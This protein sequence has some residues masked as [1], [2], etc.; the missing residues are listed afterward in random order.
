MTKPSTSSHFTAA[1]LI[2][3]L[4][5]SIIAQQQQDI[6]GGASALLAN[7]EVEA[8]LGKGIFTPVPKQPHVNKAPD[9]KPV[10]RSVAAA[11]PRTNTGGNR[12]T[13][14]GNRNTGPTRPAMDAEAYNKQG[15]DFFDAGKYDQAATAYQQAIK[16]R[17]DYADAY[18]N[19]GETY[20][21]LGRYDEAIVADNKAISLDLKSADA[22]RALGLARL[23]KNDLADAITALKR[24]NELNPNDAE[25]RNGLSLAYYNQGAAAYNDKNYDDAVA[26]YQRSEE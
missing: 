2:S 18:L 16:L 15:D 10:R 3:V 9:K 24:A 21:N 5:A 19:L 11:H 25:T 26:R 17:S 8:K 6:S 12:P 22:Y 23:H 14:S 4:A 7:A 20:Y 13:N 1:L